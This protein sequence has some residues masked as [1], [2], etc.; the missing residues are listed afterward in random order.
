[1]T[2]KFVIII[3]FLVSIIFLSQCTNHVD[4]TFETIKIA[5]HSEELINDTTIRYAAEISYLNPVSGEAK[6]QS[7]VRHVTDSWL[8]SLFPSQSS[9]TQ[10]IND[11]AEADMAAFID[12]VQRETTPDEITARIFELYV[13]PD[14]IPYQNSK[15]LSLLYSYY[16]YQGGAHGMK[17]VYCI[18]MDK[19]KATEIT[20]DMLVADQSGLLTVAEKCFREQRKIGGDEPLDKNYFFEN[21]KFV[22]SKNFVFVADG[23]RFFYQPYEIAPYS[24]GIID[25]FLPYKSIREFIRY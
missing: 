21:G 22:L 4:V 12:E 2:M 25:L 5:K 9:S 7:A 13:K 15:V 17:G 6:L 10:S 8:K 18:N 20:F 11:L 16:T 14:S 19:E 3:G 24:E 1:M 23:I